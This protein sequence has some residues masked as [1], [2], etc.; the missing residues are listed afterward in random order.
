MYNTET[1]IEKAKE[2]HGDFYDYSHVDYQGAESQD[3]QRI[4][5]NMP[6]PPF[7]KEQVGWHVFCN[8]RHK[9]C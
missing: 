1:F 6:T 4:R 9:T 7:R 2:K 3:V 5:N 8:T